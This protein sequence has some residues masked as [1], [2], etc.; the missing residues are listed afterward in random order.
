[1]TSKP[2]IKGISSSEDSIWFK[3]KAEI[4]TA[5]E[6][7]RI[8]ALEDSGRKF[9]K[10]NDL[11]DY[12]LVIDSSDSPDGFVKSDIY[13][14]IIFTKECAHLILRKYGTWEKTREQIMGSF[15]VAKPRK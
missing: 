4:Q 13:A 6:L 7:Y 3:F 14:Y 8:F 2:L 12:Y 10:Y 15:D 11:M 9:H 5:N 1:M